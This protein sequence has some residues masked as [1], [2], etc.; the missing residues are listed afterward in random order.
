MI[1]PTKDW[2]QIETANTTV[3]KRW[4]ELCAARKQTRPKHTHGR[5][6]LPQRP[7]STQRP[8]PSRPR[9]YQPTVR[10]VSKKHLRTKHASTFFYVIV[11]LF[12]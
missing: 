4:A 8:H 6:E 5:N 1:I 3:M 9:P 7:P 10:T 11:L 12:H 2:K